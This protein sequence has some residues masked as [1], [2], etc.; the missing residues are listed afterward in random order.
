MLPEICVANPQYVNADTLANISFLVTESMISHS[1]YLQV[2][3]RIV[4]R[5]STGVDLSKQLSPN[6]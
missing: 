2:P 4:W 3:W 1:M 5:L 6:Q